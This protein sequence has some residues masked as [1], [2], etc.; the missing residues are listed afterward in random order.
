LSDEDVDN[1]YITITLS[2]D[3][4]IAEFSEVHIDV[5]NILEPINFKQKFTEAAE[6]LNWIEFDP[7]DPSADIPGE[8]PETGI[9]L[10]FTFEEFS[11]ALENALKLELWSSDE[12]IY[13]GTA[14]SPKG[15]PLTGGNYALATDVPLDKPAKLDLVTKY[16]KDEELEF[17]ARLSPAAGD[18]LLELKDIKLFDDQN[19]PVT[20]KIEGSVEFFANWSRAELDISGMGFKDGKLDDVY[21]DIK[22]GDELINLEDMVGKYLKDLY[23]SAWEIR[24]VVSGPEFIA[25]HLELKDAYLNAKYTDAEGEQTRPVI[26]FEGRGTE[27]NISPEKIPENRLFTKSGGRDIFPYRDL[28]TPLKDKNNNDIGIKADM[29]LEDIFSVQPKDLYFEYGAELGIDGTTIIV[30]PKDFEE[31]LYRDSEDEKGQFSFELQAIALVPLEFGVIGDKGYGEILLYKLLDENPTDLFGRNTPDEKINLPFEIEKMPALHVAIEFPDAFF[32][33]GR[34]F[35][36]D[37]TVPLL[38]N[39]VKLHGKAISVTVGGSE[40]DEI[41]GLVPGGQAK[42][43]IPKPRLVFE[44]GNRITI[45]RNLGL[46]RI[47]FGLSGDYSINTGD[48]GLW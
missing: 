10:F 6:I 12:D 18:D 30:T 26:E 2:V 39:G 29:K 31:I 40:L 41:M 37:E 35:A 14:S 38:K 19:E 27:W 5:G 11:P 34:F 28:Q 16:S 7:Y 22:K 32:S 15:R 45:P 43:L 46:A 48:L 8:V 1:E 33:G 23:F 21:P 9:G 24:V 17:N 3:M 47:E 44:L 20:L 25:D 36:F 13:L 4:D 42:F